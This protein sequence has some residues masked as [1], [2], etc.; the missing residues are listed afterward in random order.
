MEI[1]L[2]GDMRVVNGIKANPNHK[3]Y[4]KSRTHNLA[5]P[6]TNV[7]V[8]VDWPS[9]HSTSSKMIYILG[10]ELPS[11]RANLY[12]SYFASSSIKAKTLGL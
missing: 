6:N 7:S 12:L 8:E 5:I 10:L 1:K 9:I 3:H 11:L 2:N 4:R